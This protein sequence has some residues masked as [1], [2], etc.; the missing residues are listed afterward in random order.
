MPDK[1]TLLPCPFCGFPAQHIREGNFHT[2]VCTHYY[3]QSSQIA[4]QAESKVIERWNSR[5]ALSAGD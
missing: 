3:C 4:L 1:P 2:V 5:V